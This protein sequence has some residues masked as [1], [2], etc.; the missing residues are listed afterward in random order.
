MALYDTSSQLCG[1]RHAWWPRRAREV[2]E[3][4]KALDALQQVVA[5]VELAQLHQRAEPLDLLDEVLPQTQV[6]CTV[7]AQTGPAAKPAD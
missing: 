7:T 1:V 5:Q 3:G 2:D 4:F 6:L